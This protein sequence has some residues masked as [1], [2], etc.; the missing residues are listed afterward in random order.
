M[1]RAFIAQN[2]PTGPGRIATCLALHQHGRVAG[3]ALDFLSLFGH[4]GGQIL[5]NAFQMR[6]LFFQFGHL[7]RHH[8]L[9]L[10]APHL[11]IG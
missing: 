9:H 7:I 5:A 8:M 10:L 3:Q 2:Y 1:R 11:A 4:H 6:H